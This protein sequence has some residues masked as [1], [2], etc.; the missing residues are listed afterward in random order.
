[1][2]GVLSVLTP[3]T[4]RKPAVGSKKEFTIAQPEI[5]NL[6]CDT[7]SDGDKRPINIAI[8]NALCY[9]LSITR[10][11]ALMPSAGLSARRALLPTFD[12][13]TSFDTAYIPLATK[14][15]DHEHQDGEQRETRD[16]RTRVAGGTCDLNVPLL[17]RVQSHALVS[18]PWM[19]LFS[20]LLSI[21]CAS[22]V[23]AVFGLYVAGPLGCRQWPP[24]RTHDGKP[25]SDGSSAAAQL[26]QPRGAIWIG[27]RETKGHDV[28]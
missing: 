3:C 16:E 26:L 8:P 1:V 11:D 15:V 17:L 22:T 25:T 4:L 10:L 13:P 2:I 6:V 18:R 23:E 9:V 20:P 28:V 24:D 14:P 7:F 21:A 5:S 27:G 12:E 19:T